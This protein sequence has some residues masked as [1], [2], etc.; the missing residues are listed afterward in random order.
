MPRRDAPLAVRLDNRGKNGGLAAVGSRDEG[1]GSTFSH[2]LC[3]SDGGKQKRVNR[4]V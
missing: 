3:L 2:N 4:G 1:D